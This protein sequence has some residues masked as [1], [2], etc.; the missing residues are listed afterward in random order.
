[1]VKRES[2]DVDADVSYIPAMVVARLPRKQK[3]KKKDLPFGV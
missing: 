1:M 2:I 3:E